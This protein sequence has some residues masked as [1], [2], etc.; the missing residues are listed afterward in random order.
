MLHMSTR[1]IVMVE[2]IQISGFRANSY[3]RISV[4]EIIEAD[5]ADKSVE[6]DTL[7]FSNAS[8]HYPMKL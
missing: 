5:K 7:P 4:S 2:F 6:P 8:L 1:R 3:L